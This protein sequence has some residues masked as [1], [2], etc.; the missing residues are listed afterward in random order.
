MA[1]RR[2]ISLHSD[3]LWRCCSCG[4]T[5]HCN[6]HNY[7]QSTVYTH[8]LS[9]VAMCGSL[10]ELHEP[11]TELSLMSTYIHT[12][13]HCTLYC[14][15]RNVSTATGLINGQMASESNRSCKFSGNHCTLASEEMSDK[16]NF[17][18]IY[19]FVHYQHGLQVSH[20]EGDWHNVGSNDAKWRKNCS[21]G[22][23]KN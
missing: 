19:L 22:L 3:V 15:A 8:R 17:H 5:F 1:T 2:D 16:W 11:D 7:R 4:W 21:F 23:D 9:N 20:V 18:C 10:C 13:F 6:R 12:A 14:S